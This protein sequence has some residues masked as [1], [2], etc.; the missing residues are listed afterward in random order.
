MN[1]FLKTI[2]LLTMLVMRLSIS[3]G[4]SNPE[5][6]KMNSLNKFK[7][8]ENISKFGSKLK[9]VSSNGIRKE[10]LYDDFN[11][12]GAFNISDDIVFDAVKLTFENDKVVMVDFVKMINSSN[13][14]TEAIS[15]HKKLAERTSIVFGNNKKLNPNDNSGI[16][17]VYWESKNR[18]LTL[19][20][21][22]MGLDKG[23]AVHYILSDSKIYK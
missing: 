1:K 23:S 8:N 22:Y 3:F 21:N 12:T 7:L 13:H 20:V 9:L 6:D 16:I 4:Q 5:L 17:S 11:D 19:T 18:I 15:F 14:Y 2:S 10:Y